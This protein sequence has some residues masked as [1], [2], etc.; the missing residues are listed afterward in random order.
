MS[1]RIYPALTEKGVEN[2][3]TDWWLLKEA[4]FSEMP[5]FRH[6][7]WKVSE[8]SFGY[9]QNWEWVEDQTQESIERLI[10]RPTGGGIVRH[11]KDW[12]YCLVLPR[13]HPS[14]SMPSLDLYEKIH[15]AI[16]DAL[17]DQSIETFLQPCPAKKKTAIPGDCF[18]EPV[19]KDL[20]TGKSEKKIAGAAMK[21]TKS[22]I[23]FQ[24][25]LDLGFIEKTKFD[26][27]SFGESFTNLLARLLKAE[28]EEVN[29][30]ENFHKERESFCQEFESLRW[31][32]N[33]ERN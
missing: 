9:G 26:P 2:M 29:W 17:E 30:P 12:T 24:G 15:Q 20:M 1:L 32:K 3:A 4:V 22:A 7:Q 11:G 14:F 13:M 10:R 31:R 6:Y 28:K 25:T 16:A 19:G 27:S 21:R 5:A 23:L 33:R 18:Q 8:I